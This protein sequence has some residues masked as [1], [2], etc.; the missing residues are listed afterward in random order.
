MNAQKMLW[1]FFPEMTLGDFPEIGENQKYEYLRKIVSSGFFFQK[2]RSTTSHSRSGFFFQKW[3]W[4]ISQVFGKNHFHHV[5]SLSDDVTWPM[6]IWVQVEL[7]MMSQI[8]MT[9]W[10]VRYLWRHDKSK[11]NFWIFFP[12]MTLGDIPEMHGI[13]VNRTSLKQTVPR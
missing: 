8:N 10:V 5:I 13:R 7:V 9:S 3:R 4:V 11:T 6:S 2:W 12:E 1:I